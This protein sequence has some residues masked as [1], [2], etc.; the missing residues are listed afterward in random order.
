MKGRKVSKRGAVELSIGTIVII[1][2]A[3]SMLI[4]GIVLIKNIFTGATKL[5]DMSFDQVESEMAAV[6]G[7]ERELSLLPKVDE[8]KLKGGT[9][10]V[11]AIGIRNKLQGTSGGEARFAYE[12]TFDDFK[13]CGFSENEIRGWIKGEEGT[14]GQIG[15]GQL[16]IEKISIDLPEGTTLCKFKIRVT[17]TQNGQGYAGDSFFLKVIG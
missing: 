1:V 5:A 9:S 8:M 3:M 11:F 4:L 10:E 12:L 17:V 14:I 15:P 6:Y 13:D 16:H 2:L 7:V